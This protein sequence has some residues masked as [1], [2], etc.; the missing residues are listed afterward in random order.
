VSNCIIVIGR[1]NLWTR[2]TMDILAILDSKGIHYEH[3]GGAEFAI[4]CPAQGNHSDGVDALPSFNINIEKMKG[5]CFACGFSMN[6]ER[7]QMWLLGDSLDETQI[8]ILNLRGKLRRMDE[9]D[10]ALDFEHED[11]RL[12]LMPPGKPWDREYRGVSVETYRTLGAIECQRG[13]YENRICFPITQHGRLLGVDAR[14]L[15]DEK[16]K[17]LRPK[18]CDAKKWLYP[19]DL[20]KSQKIRKVILCEGIY[21]AIGYY[22]QMGVAEAQCYFGTNNYSQH[23]TLLLLELG[24]EYVVFWPDND[25]AGIDAMEKICPQVSEWLDCRYIPPEVLPE[26]GRDLADFNKE[27]IEFFLSKMR[28]WK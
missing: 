3:K 13:R 1:L 4:I 15:G 14:A 6:P 11:D 19:F 23:N 27:E 24:L 5:H 22:N 2:R 20:G 12:T 8:Q 7:L 10:L 9:H 18:G 21:H 25:K 16:P 28:R 17:Y 26:D